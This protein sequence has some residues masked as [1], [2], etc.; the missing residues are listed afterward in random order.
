MNKSGKSSRVA[1]L[2][3]KAEARLW[4]KTATTGSV[5]PDVETLELIHELEIHQIELELQNEELIQAQNDAQAAA[6][7]YRELYDFAPSGFFTLSGT[8]EIIELNL[9]G[10]NMIGKER[11]GLINS[12]FGF[13]VSDDTRPIFSLFLR[14]VFEGKAKESCEVILSIPDGLPKF[15]HLSGIISEN[16]EH[17][18]VTVLDITESKD[19]EQEL[20]IAKESAE[21]SDRL[22]LAF[23]ANMSHEIRTPMNGILGFTELLKEPLLTGEEQQKYIDI[24]EKSGARMLNII[25]DIISI[26]KVESGQMGIYISETNINGQME[27]IYTFFKPEIEKKG[28]RLSYKNG[29]PDKEAIIKTDRE[30]IYAIL[31]NLVKNAIKFT[32]EGTIEFGYEKKGNYLEFFVKDTGTGVRQEQKKII[33][34]RFRQGS[35][36]LTRNYEGAGLGLSISKAYVE[37]LGGKIWVDES[38]TPLIAGNPGGKGSSFYF[39]IPCKTEPEQIIEQ[40]NA[41][42]IDSK[43]NQVRALKILIAEDDETSELFLGIVVKTFSREILKVSTGEEA[44]EACHNNPDIDLVLMDI[45][46]PEM[47]G[48]EATRQIRQFNKDVVIIAQTA[49]ALAGESDKAMEAGCNDYISKP[50]N[51]FLLKKLI[52]KYFSTRK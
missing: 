32:S 47:D 26:S 51:Q 7:K 18:L 37:M 2:R 15:V 38:D 39:T 40:K 9:S 46:M 19:S 5:P 1:Y 34:E 29:L 35:E 8:G 28:I 30:K 21:E 36:S 4:K 6:D 17:C 23:L 27:Y 13:F 10:A 48:C 42:L 11:R 16:R 24:I 44:V 12:M 20:I 33:F 25:N 43:E 22:K 45:K 52:K 14:K 49:F 31:T 3:Q 50:I 41:D